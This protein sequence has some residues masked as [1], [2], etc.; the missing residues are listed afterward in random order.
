MAHPYY[1]YFEAPRYHAD[2]EAMFKLL[3]K[4][5]FKGFGKKSGPL[6]G[7]DRGEIRVWVNKYNAEWQVVRLMAWG[8]LRCANT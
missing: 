6:R 4:L 3:H 1:D 5:G 2:K 8:W 7:F